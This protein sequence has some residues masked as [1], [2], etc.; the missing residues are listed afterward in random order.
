VGDLFD[1]PSIVI[2]L[3]NKI[4]IVLTQFMTALITDYT[5]AKLYSGNISWGPIKANLLSFHR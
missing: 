2:D 1:S 5:N 3:E 4:S